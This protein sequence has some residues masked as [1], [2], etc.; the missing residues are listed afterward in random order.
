M[1]ITKISGSFVTKLPIGTMEL[2][3]SPIGIINCSPDEFLAKISDFKENALPVNGTYR[4]L[5]LNSG[6]K[7]IS[8]DYKSKNG[9]QLFWEKIFNADKKLTKESF[10]DIFDKTTI[11]YAPSTG[12]MKQLEA[13]TPR[14]TVKYIFG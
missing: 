7:V 4:E 9:F 14:G 12:E 13:S 8:S 2:H 1:H 3:K 10:I 6:E 11:E 5:N